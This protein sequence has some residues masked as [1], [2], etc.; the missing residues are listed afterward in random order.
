MEGLRTAP[1]VDYPAVARL[2]LRALERLHRAFARCVRTARQAA[3]SAR[4]GPQRAEPRA[5]GAVRCLARALRGAA[6][7]AGRLAQLAPRLPQAGWRG[8]ARFRARAGGADRLL[9]VPAVACGR[10]ARRGAGDRACRRHADRALSRP[11]RRA[12]IRTAPTP[13]PSRTWLRAECGSARRR[14][15]QPQGQ[16]WGLAPLMPHALRARGLRALRRAAAAEHASRRRAPHRSRAGPAGAG[17]GCRPSA[18]CRAP[19]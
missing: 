4:S 16:D 6:A 19:M 12:S 1:L 15:T 5:S 9:R 8:G 3:R 2:E 13:G 17:S 11:C 10:A 18:T 14:T 7:G